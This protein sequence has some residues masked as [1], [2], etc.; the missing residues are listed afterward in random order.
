MA[1]FKPLLAGRRGELVLFA[2]FTFLYLAPVWL[3]RYLPTQDGPSH[4]Y[5]AIILK[6]YTQPHT[7]YAEFYERRWQQFPN[8]TAHAAL[9]VL[10]Y[11][12][13]P[14]IAEKL[15][16]SA[17]LLGFA[18]SFRYFL[19]S[20]GEEAG[21]LAGLGL[22]FVYHRFFLMGFYNY[23]LSLALYWLI[24]GYCLRTPIRSRITD[25]AVL[26]ILFTTAYFT[27]L[28]GFLLAAGSVLSIALLTPIERERRTSVVAIALAPAIG[29]TT[30]YL[31]RTGFWPSPEAGALFDHVW[32]WMTGGIPLADLWNVLNSVNEGLFATYEAWYCPI[33][34]LVLFF[35]EGMVYL[36]LCSGRTAPIPGAKPAPRWPI[37]VLAA[38][39]SVLYLILPDHLG[40]H[41]GFLR[42]R[43][44][45]LPPL[46][47]VA[48]FRPP[49][50]LFG[51]RLLPGILYLLLGINLVLVT[52]YVQSGN[53]KLAEFTAARQAVGRNHTLVVYCPRS[54][55][56]LVDALLHAG[57]YYC[58]DSHNID[59][60]NYEAEEAYWPIRYRADFHQRW[61]HPLEIFHDEYAV[62]AILV[63]DAP[64]D[65]PA[66]LSASYRQVYGQGRLQVF[67]SNSARS[68]TAAN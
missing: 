32:R 50:G 1:K 7:R 54:A 64:A 44:V 25:T 35:Y 28:I 49:S 39:L 33:G 46:L 68:E 19:T 2:L 9:V 36:A 45:V 43:L 65:L 63:W 30:D 5:N 53:R 16:V 6:D 56:R 40:Q 24:L 51:R 38:L 58:L 3:F 4:V 59:V 61:E 52:R 42:A 62:D 41:G 15:L 26:M 34:L 23:C 60:R 20:F 48:G 57:A 29:L 17:Y 21:Q 18:W 66:K 27:H 31:L 37:L 67:L 8:W 47:L 12:F 55:P 22:L 11:L 13:P 10:M 14:L